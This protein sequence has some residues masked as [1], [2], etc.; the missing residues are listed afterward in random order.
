MAAVGLACVG[1]DTAPGNVTGPDPDLDGGGST[2]AGADASPPSNDAAPPSNDASST[3]D[4][5]PDCKATKCDGDD[6]VDCNGAR[7]KCELGCRSEE[8]GPRCATFEPQGPATVADMRRT[9][10]ADLVLTTA[11]VIDVRSGEI[12][13]S[14]GA[15][16][17]QANDDPA[18]NQ[19]KNNVAFRVESGVAIFIAKNI[20]FNGAVSFEGT[21]GGNVD[22]A[23]ATLPVMF[24]ATN[25]LRINALLDIPCGSLGGGVGGIPGVVPAGGTEAGAGGGPG[26][27]KRGESK[28]GSGGGHGT[29]GGQA[30]A[31]G[32][33]P[34]LVAGAAGGPTNNGTFVLAGGSG[35]GGGV[36]GDGAGVKNS[37]G[38]A[39]G[40]AI[41]FVAGNTLWLGDGTA[42]QGVNAKGCGGKSLVGGQINVAGSGGGSG[43]FVSLEA[44]VVQAAAKSGLA[45][46]G[47]GGSGWGASNAAP[48][49]DG[50][51]STSPAPGGG[52]GTAH[53]CN[54]FGGAGA[55]GDNPT[56]VSGVNGK[57]STE[58]VNCATSSGGGG[59]GGI[60]RIVISSLSGDVTAAEPASF[61]T[62]PKRGTAT[63]KLLTLTSEP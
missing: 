27:G 35:G 63:V 17:R 19:V 20:T 57:T 43:G 2:E 24:V 9:G 60:G 6:I 44:P 4:S 46:N 10:L 34:G 31:A 13:T 38:G 59:G 47:G 7:T 62:S 37:K 22:P 32:S 33:G 45:A 42:A 28:T 12:R 54:G 29:V 58:N 8:E 51:F 53:A 39:G 40:G 15:S 5:G 30:G 14:G 1:D 55:A 50:Q 18:Q 25:D 61:F 23:Y 52:S 21:E 16:L 36:G 48:G 3:N 56:A 26:A 41:A 11:Q 49:K